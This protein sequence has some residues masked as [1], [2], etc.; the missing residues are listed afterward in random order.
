MKTEIVQET[1][2]ERKGDRKMKINKFALLIGFA[3][4]SML[5]FEV[6]AHADEGN[7]LTILTFNKPIEI[8]GKVLPAGTY[9]FKLADDD[10]LHTVRVFNADGTRLI[11]TLQTISAQ[12]MEPT[13]ETVV[14]LAVQPGGGP[15]ALVKWFYPGEMIGHEFMYSK[16]EEHQIAQD[17]KQTFPAKE[18]PQSGD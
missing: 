7:Q 14:T 3:I 16:Q 11:A 18:T 10:N 4:T 17:Q 2:Q 1:E 12:R 8:P 6:A 5:F 13:G 15:E 9:Q